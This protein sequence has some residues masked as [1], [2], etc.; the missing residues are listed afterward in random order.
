MKFLSYALILLFLSIILVSCSTQHSEIVLAKFSDDKITIGEFEKAYS[1]NVGGVETAKKDSISKLKNFLD[2]YMNFRMKLR[3]AKVRSFDGDENLQNELIDYKKKVGVSYILEKQ[4]VEPGITELYE[5]RKWE[6]RVSHLMI[7]PDS[8][9]LET[10]RM[11]AQ[12]IL[13]SIKQ[14]SSFEE[15]VKRH[16]QD[17][18]S[19]PKGGDIFFVT[20][21]L[22]PYEFESACYKTQPGQ[23]YPEVVQTRYGFHLIKVTEKRER[24]PK[25]K[26]SHILVSFTNDSGKVDTA[27]ALMKMDTV[28]TKLKSGEDFGELA[29]QYSA[30]TG[31]KQNGGDLGFF[32]R[33]MM[34]PEF[35]EAAFNLNVG[36]VSKVVKTNF[37]YHLIKLTEKAPYPT[38]ADD[39]ENLKKIFKQQRYQTE[40]DTLVNRASRKYNYKVNEQTIDFIV[41]Q[42]DTLKLNKDYSKLDVVKDKEFFSYAGKSVKFGDVFNQVVNNPNFS[43]RNISKDILKNAANTVRSE[44]ILEEEALQLDK[45]NK[46]FSELMDDYKNGIYIF[47]LQEDEVWN[48]IEIDTLRMKEFYEKTKEKYVWPDRVNFSEIYTKKDSLINFVYVALKGGVKFDSLA[49]KYTERPGYKERAGNWGLMDVKSNQLSQEVAKLNNVG[50]F[51][52]PF[53]YG[54]GN[55]IVMLVAKEPSRIKTFEEA[56]AEVSGSFQEAESKRLENEY[57]DSLKKR[58]EPVIYYDKLEQAFKP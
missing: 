36:D 48:K 54:G 51:S 12:N 6:L 33:R 43:N 45:V 52:A 58:Y 15:M 13:D 11:K 39:K 9:G 32:E 37:G 1:K 26:A 27:M 2:L 4:I 34:V 10:A 49:F 55:S 53:K 7:R 38:F 20:A 56:K 40:Y 23:V 44:M 25:I 14:G 57:I 18:F 21:G 35:D 17:Q 19:K 3:D 42:G 29:K 50:D 28:L 5:N 16:S 46:E 47:K 30:D 41:Q 24:V 31:S 22:L 8:T